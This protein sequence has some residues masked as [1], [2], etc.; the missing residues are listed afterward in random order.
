MVFLAYAAKKQ[1]YTA[2][3]ALPLRRRAASTPRPVAVFLRARKPCVVARFRFFGWYVLLGICG[4]QYTKYGPFAIC[5]NAVRVVCVSIL[6]QCFL[7]F[8][9]RSHEKYFSTGYAQLTVKQRENT[10]REQK[11][12]QDIHKEYNAHHRL[13]SF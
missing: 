8:W 6:W 3:F 12:L 13:Y 7:L 4:A 2:N 10:C 5:C 1:L 9:Q 11:D